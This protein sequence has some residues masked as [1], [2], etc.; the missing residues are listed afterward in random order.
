[1]N[2]AYPRELNT[3]GYHLRKVRLNREL[4]QLDVARILRVTTDTVTNWELNRNQPRA[5]FAK[6]IIS[7]LG[8]I[9]F[10]FENVPL[11]E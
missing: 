10:L 1:V 3:L 6:R 5:K 7:F 9:P 8:Y 2:P 11:H 4:S